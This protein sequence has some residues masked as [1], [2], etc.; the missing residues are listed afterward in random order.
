MYAPAFDP[1]PQAGDMVV[2]RSDVKRRRKEGNILEESLQTSPKRT[3]VHAQ[4]KFA[5]G[6]SNMSSPA[7][8]PVKDKDKVK[9]NGT[10]LSPELIPAKRPKTEDFLTFLCF[11][12]TPI[13]PPCLDFFNIASVQEAADEEQ[14]SSMGDCSRESTRNSRLTSASVSG[15]RTRDLTGTLLKHRLGTHLRLRPANNTL[16]SLVDSIKFLFSA[17]T[18]NMIEVFKVPRQR[19]P[20][21]GSGVIR[22]FDRSEGVR[23]RKPPTAVQALKRK[24][25]EQRLAK[26]RASSLKKLA[27]RGTKVGPERILYQRNLKFYELKKTVRRMKIVPRKMKSAPKTDVLRRNK[28]IMKNR[29]RPI[30]RDG[31]RTVEKPVNKTFASSVSDFSSDDDQPLAKKMKPIDRAS[32]SRQLARKVIKRIV[33][34]RIKP[35]MITRSQQ[36]APEKEQSDTKMYTRPPRKT[37]EA[38]AIYMELLGRKLITPEAEVDEDSLSIDSFPE[39]PNARRIER[40]E[41]EIK[42]RASKEK[43][44]AEMAKEEKRLLPVQKSKLEVENETAKQK[45]LD[46][47]R[48]R[49]LSAQSKRLIQ[50]KG[51]ETI[52]RGQKKKKE[53]VHKNIDD[54]KMNKEKKTEETKDKKT[55]RKIEMIK[56]KEIIGEEKPRKVKLK[57]NLSTKLKTEVI[58][59]VEN[60]R[61]K[62]K[63]I[64]IK[65]IEISSGAVPKK[66]KIDASASKNETIMKSRTKVHKEPEDN[67]ACFSVPSSKSKEIAEEI[68][69]IKKG[70]NKSDES[71]KTKRGEI[72]ENMSRKADGLQNKELLSEKREELSKV[73]ERLTQKNDDVVQSIELPAANKTEKLKSEKSCKNVE[74]DAQKKELF[75]EKELVK[76]S[77]KSKKTDGK[78]FLA[79]KSVELNVT[80]KKFED[81]RSSFYGKSKLK[82]AS[83]VKGVKESIRNIEESSS[84]KD[85]TVPKMVSDNV[86]KSDDNNASKF[87]TSG[88]MTFQNLKKLARR[89]TLPVN[90]EVAKLSTSDSLSEENLMTDIL[91]G[92]EKNKSKVNMSNEQIEKWLNDS[93]IYEADAKNHRELVSKKKKPKGFNFRRKNMP[94]MTGIPL[95]STTVG[96]TLYKIGADVQQKTADTSK[97][98]KSIASEEKTSFPVKPRVPASLEITS[99]A[100]VVENVEKVDKLSL[101]DKKQNYSQDNT[102][103][104]NKLLLE[105]KKHDA[106]IRQILSSKSQAFQDRIGEKKSI[107]QQRQIKAPRLCFLNRSQSCPP[108][109]HSTFRRRAKRQSSSPVIQTPT[110]S[111]VH[112]SPL[113]QALPLLQSPTLT[114]S[115]PRLTESVSSNQL[116]P[117]TQGIPSTQSLILTQSVPS[118][119]SQ[120]IQSTVVQII[121][122]L[123]ITMRSVPVENYVANKSQQQQQLLLLQNDAV[124]TTLKSGS[125]S[126]TSIAVQVNLDNEASPE[127]QVQEPGSM[128][129]STQTDVTEE[130]EDDSEGHL[131]YIP[132][133]QPAGKSGPLAAPP[134]QLIQGVAVKLGTEGPTGPNQRVIMRAK[135]VTKPPNFNRGP[136][137]SIGRSVLTRPPV[138]GVDTNTGNKPASLTTSSKLSGLKQQIGRERRGSIEINSPSTSGAKST[139]GGSKRRGDHWTSVVNVNSI[140][141]VTNTVM[142]SRYA[143]ELRSMRSSQKLKLSSYICTPSNAT[144]FPHLG[145]PAQMVEAPIFHPTEKEFQDPLEYIDRIRPVAEKFG[146][147]RVVPPP[148]FKPECKVSDDMRFLAYNQY[149]HKNVASLGT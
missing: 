36:Q 100:H 4:R 62:K 98:V 120:L 107:F 125:T 73:P 40:R 23:R 70:S 16:N 142:K 41:S 97:N 72:K 143:R 75:S 108:N 141:N 7:L 82:T 91:L 130:E 111:S 146:L 104:G 103:E 87:M 1:T 121:P 106:S 5:Q 113:T 52:S 74:N 78:E 126:S 148:N 50:K 89:E 45:R 47:I 37:K 8:T 139:A 61:S 59:N 77:D 149:V 56:D 9:T 25:Q 137:D 18:E 128:E 54:K 22:K 132:L 86:Q 12:G 42:A 110:T 13:L 119:Q 79:K 51:E 31:L 136:T 35:R 19:T 83:T 102:T 140:E 39:L 118:T 109:S 117:S 64:S 80:E 112:S 27:Q 53:I 85:K 29:K 60:E 66:N 93:Y 21:M 6:S 44:E 58:S 76:N 114:E 144:S 10:V 69:N 88:K 33:T 127:M 138:Q 81:R 105:S 145:S 122:T 46:M 90:G 24:Y 65:K 55:Q 124:M 133:Q 34:K 57:D 38:A 49:K 26:Q 96:E 14:G 48:A 3:K 101:V 68:K 11:R 20:F 63:E 134:Q 17:Y 43:K 71:L 99:V 28:S 84:Q 30:R 94:V 32:S 116:P 115:P 2:S 135:L 95:Y 123:P 129:C 15:S 131:F 147:C 92:R 67:V